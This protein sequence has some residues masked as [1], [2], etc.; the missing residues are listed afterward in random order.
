MYIYISFKY[1]LKRSVALVCRNVTEPV[2]AHMRI[3]NRP[4]YLYLAKNLVSGQLLLKSMEFP[5]PG[6]LTSSGSYWPF[7]ALTNFEKEIAIKW[8]STV[9]SKEQV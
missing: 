7:P 4:S 9:D 6:L 1:T 2:S 5:R 8:F 3:Q